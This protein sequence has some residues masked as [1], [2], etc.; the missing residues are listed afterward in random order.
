MEYRKGDSAQMKEL[1]EVNIESQ[2]VLLADKIVYAQRREWCDTGMRQLSL[3]LM[4]YRQF[5]SYDNHDK[6]PVIIWLCGGAFS[7]MKRNIWAPEMVYY[8]KR[9][10]AVALV[11]YTVNQRMRF[12]EPIIDVK[13][14]IRFVRA[15]ADELNLDAVNIAIMGESAGGILATLVALTNGEKAY[16]KGTNLEYASD[17]Q[18]V[19][20]FYG[21]AGEVESKEDHSQDTDP[22]TRSTGSQNV[23]ESMPDM[24]KMI[25]PGTPPFFVLFGT[26]D[27]LL[28]DTNGEKFYDG[29]GKAGNECDLCL[30]RG[31]G[32]A[33][34]HFFQPVVKDRVIR[35]LDKHLKTK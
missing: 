18:A 23:F 5:Y 13:E 24:M 1:I 14:A 35:F 25:K 15:N 22:D 29:M 6:L 7:E 20:P 27:K 11:E 3:G 33:D 21:I 31:A 10:Y 16:D 30:V 19:V 4:K 8:A 28:S 34:Q 12:P 26:N 32:H 2:V 17:V 9:G